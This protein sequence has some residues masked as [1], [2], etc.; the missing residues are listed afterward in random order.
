VLPANCDKDWLVKSTP[1]ERFRTP[2]RHRGGPEPWSKVPWPGGLQ[3]RAHQHLDGLPGGGRTPGP[4]ASPDG[5]RTNPQRPEIKPH[6]PDFTIFIKSL[7]RTFWFAFVKLCLAWAKET[8]VSV[9]PALFWPDPDFL[10]HLQKPR[11]FHHHCNKKN[12]GVWFGLKIK[13][14]SFFRT[15]KLVEIFLL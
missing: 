5:H 2:G 7:L 8:E 12:V 4:P 10:Q 6:C 1:G 9:A 14:S 15:S 11:L 13:V 3:G